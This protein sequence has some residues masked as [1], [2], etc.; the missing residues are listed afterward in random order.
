[1]DV[2]EI[3]EARLLF[4]L[5]PLEVARYSIYSENYDSE[6]KDGYAR[7]MADTG[8]DSTF[9]AG[10]LVEIFD[11]KDG[12]CEMFVTKI[13]STAEID[14]SIRNSRTIY[15]FTSLQDLLE[16]C[17]M[18]SERKMHGGKAYKD[19][20]KTTYFLVL[21]KEA[22]Y[23]NEFRAK[24]EGSGFAEYLSEH[25][26]LFSNNAVDVLSSFA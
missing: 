4:V 24:K 2:I 3:D 6:M 13:S 21:D 26:L 25:C 9:H 18:L 15:I 7:L 16:A 11:S 5:D 12:G 20:N 1:M 19:T 8:T 22:P 14:G 17:R 23:V 10:V